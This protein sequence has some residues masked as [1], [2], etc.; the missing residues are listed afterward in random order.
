MGPAGHT[1][2]IIEQILPDNGSGGSGPTGDDGLWHDDAYF[3]TD[4]G[5][6][7]DVAY[8]FGDDGFWHDDAYF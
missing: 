2:Q 4:D 7:H 8:F 6:W 3:V 5:L 1:I